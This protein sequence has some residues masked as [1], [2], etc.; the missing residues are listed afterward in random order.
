VPFYGN[1]IVAPTAWS[2][3][4]ALSVDIAAVG[5]TATIHGTAANPTAGRYEFDIGNGQI[6]KVSHSLDITPD[7]TLAGPAIN[8]RDQASA[9]A[10]T[11]WVYLYLLLNTGNQ[12]TIGAVW[13]ASPPTVGPT[14]PPGWMSPIFA[15]AYRLNGTPQLVAGYRRN[16]K[17]YYQTLFNIVNSATAPTVE[18][19]V[20]LVNAVPPTA[21]D[22]DIGNDTNN[23]IDFNTAGTQSEIFRIVTGV[24]YYAA[25]GTESVANQAQN[26]QIKF[27][28]PNIAAQQLI[29]LWTITGVINGANT[30]FGVLAYSEP[31]T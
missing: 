8:G 27:S 14:A 13:S 7:I 11:S 25:I 1:A 17:F 21:W 29:W 28:A 20:S 19:T 12:L 31:L 30:S 23:F 6:R 4:Q 26:L 2:R 24:N 3:V 16:D 10:I 5:N 15:G 9:F 22:Y 18:Q